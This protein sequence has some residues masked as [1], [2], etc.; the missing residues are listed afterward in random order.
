M[1]MDERGREEEKKKKRERE[2][3]EEKGRESP[4]TTDEDKTGAWRDQRRSGVETCVISV[5]YCYYHEVH[6]TL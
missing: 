5:G 6:T 4:V 2:R 1:K 3:E